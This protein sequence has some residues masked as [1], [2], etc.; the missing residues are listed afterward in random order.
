MYVRDL[1]RRQLP[2]CTDIMY[3]DTVGSTVSQTD[4]QKY[5]ETYGK[6]RWTAIALQLSHATSLYV[7][8]SFTVCLF[9]FYK[10][11]VFV[12][13][14]ISPPRIK[15]AASNFARCFIGVLGKESPILENS[16]PQKPKIGRIDQPPGIR[17]YYGKALTRIPTLGYACVTYEY[18]LVLVRN[19]MVRVYMSMS[20]TQPAPAMFA[21]ATARSVCDNKVSILELY[22]FILLTCKSDSEHVSLPY[23]RIDNLA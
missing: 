11:C 9:L 4:M 14:R 17:F 23:D 2:A 18:Y 3:T 16:A 13:L 19:D 6:V 15:L 20:T 5:H 21:A 22:L 7:D 8:I 1:R 12:R 10:S